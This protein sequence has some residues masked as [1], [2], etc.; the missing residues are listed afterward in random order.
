MRGSQAPHLGRDLP[1]D[2]LGLARQFI[3]ARPPDPT[4]GRQQR[5]GLKNIGLARS[6]RPMNRNR[7]AIKDQPRQPVAAEMR[8]AQLRDGQTAHAGPPFIC[9]KISCGG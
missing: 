1:A 7:P 6:V 4:T 9:S 8:Q 3:R 2:G 5:H